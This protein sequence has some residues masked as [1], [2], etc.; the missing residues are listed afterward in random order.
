[1]KTKGNPEIYLSNNHELTLASA[2]WFTTFDDAC[3]TLWW[4]FSMTGCKESL[5][6]CYIVN[7]EDLIA[8]WKSG[9]W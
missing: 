1:M 2:W 6:D 7:M 5:R 9:R 3:V 4:W 8:V